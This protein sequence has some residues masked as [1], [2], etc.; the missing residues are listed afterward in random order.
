[1]PLLP[2]PTQRVKVGRHDV[3]PEVSAAVVLVSLVAQEQQLPTGG[4][5]GGHPVRPVG[6]ASHAYL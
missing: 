3:T 5:D 1:M 6:L 2:A 4:D